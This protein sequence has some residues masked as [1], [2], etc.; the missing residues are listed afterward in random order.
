[1]K[2]TILPEDWWDKWVRDEWARN[3]TRFLVIETITLGL[4]SWLSA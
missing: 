3:T 4:E 1:M 2:A